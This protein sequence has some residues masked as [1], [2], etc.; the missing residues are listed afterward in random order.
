MNLRRRRRRGARC[1]SRVPRI[2]VPKIDG[3][4]TPRVPLGFRLASGWRSTKVQSVCFSRKSV[5]GRAR[6]RFEVDSDFSLGE[7]VDGGWE[8]AKAVRAG[9]AGPDRTFD[10]Q[11]SIKIREIK[12]SGIKNGWQ[13]WP[14]GERE[15]EEREGRAM[16]QAEEDEEQD[17]SR[18]N[19]IF[20]NFIRCASIKIQPP[21]RA[22]TVTPPVSSL[23]AAAHLH[24]LPRV[25][26]VQLYPHFLSSTRDSPTRGRTFA[27]LATNSL[28]LF[29]TT[30]NSCRPM[31]NASTTQGQLLRVRRRR[32]GRWRG[33]AR[34][35]RK[36]RATC[37]Y[38]CY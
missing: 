14:S 20:S 1:G 23:P 33:S 35:R 15:I 13:S 26:A 10:L 37:T 27:P 16:R 18:D 4:A 12:K 31:R 21:C 30:G 25:T 11:E 36:G 8:V 24:L 2:I 9:S 7:M 22:N 34:G 5:P 17:T 38:A 28:P 3:V 29:G 6:R 19:L 32:G